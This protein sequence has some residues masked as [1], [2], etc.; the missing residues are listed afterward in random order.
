MLIK[1]YSHLQ[2]YSSVIL[3]SFAVI[4][5]T[6]ILS[7][8]ILTDLEKIIFNLMADDF[9]NLISGTLDDEYILSGNV[10]DNI[11]DEDVAI[12]DT[13]YESEDD[14]DNINE[15]D[16]QFEL[17]DEDQSEMRVV[18][19]FL[20]KTCGCNLRNQSPCSTVFD[21]EHLLNH[22]AD[23]LQLTREEKDL[24][25]LTTIRNSIDDDDLNSKGVIRKNSRCL[26]YYHG[27]RICQQT[28]LMM[29]AIGARKLYDLIR[30][31]KI[32]RSS[33]PRVHG[34]TGRLP[35]NTLSFDGVSQIVPSKSKQ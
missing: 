11:A 6:G 28:F 12:A 3:R 9:S 34:N 16:D 5:R 15:I 23:I 13:S 22:R 35:K 7:I 30:Y 18:E 8:I 31:Y 19:E 20:T 25:L 33:T 26:M 21:R 17:R 1:A 27:K 29:H 14:F 24:V 4:S 32:N 10:N 2:T